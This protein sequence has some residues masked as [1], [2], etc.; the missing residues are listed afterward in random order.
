VNGMCV[1]TGGTSGIGRAAALA[2]ARDTAHLVLVGRSA[3]RGA[4]ITRLVRQAAPTVDVRFF[5][6]DLSQRREV[7]RLARTIC[8]DFEHVD[9]LINNAGARF[10]IYD[11][12]ED[13]VERTFATNHLGHFL[14]TNL[15]LEHLKHAPAARVITVTSSAHAAANEDG[16]WQYANHDYDRRQAYAKS[17]LANVLFA[18]ELSTRLTGT[19]VT[20]NAVDPGV[21]ATRFALNN[22]LT[23]WMKHVI[24]H[25]TVGSLRSAESAADTVVYAATSDELAGLSGFLFRQRR[26]VEGSP[27]DWARSLSTNLWNESAKLTGLDAPTRHFNNGLCSRLNF[28]ILTSPY[29][30]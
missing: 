17:K 3:R 1:I 14:L 16:R 2:L 8:R 20:S 18:L 15:L 24:S 5:Q 30:P 10:D 23:A 12:T 4:Q 6:A 28:G 7:H 22:G 27:P 9:V 19:R 29:L 21:A 26:I 13:G 11:E 25:A